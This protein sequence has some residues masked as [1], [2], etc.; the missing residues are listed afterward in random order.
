MR[1]ASAVASVSACFDESSWSWI[2]WVRAAIAFL[3]SGPSFQK[4][5]ANTMIE[6]LP[7]AQIS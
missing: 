2:F 3:T 6:A 5:R 7:A 4:S 1:A